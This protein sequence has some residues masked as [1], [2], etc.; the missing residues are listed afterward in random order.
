[1]INEYVIEYGWQVPQ[2]GQD[3][4]MYAKLSDKFIERLAVTVD[5][6]PE[7]IHATSLL[8]AYASLNSGRFSPAKMRKI[9][10]KC[11]KMRKALENISPD[12]YDIL[13]NQYIWHFTDRDPTTEFKVD[14]SGKLL[15]EPIN[16]LHEALETISHLSEGE[17]GTLLQDIGRRAKE[18]F[19][20][21]SHDPDLSEDGIFKT[22][23]S[24]TGAFHDCP[25]NG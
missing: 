21:F 4:R 13:V 9:K 20:M 22:G 11:S 25:V 7:F 17:G 24:K 3:Y 5:D 2:S 15:T 16:I 10:N 1:M 23:T 19:D 14:K 18:I 8:V 6:Y 12:A